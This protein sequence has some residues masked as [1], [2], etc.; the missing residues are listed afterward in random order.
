MLLAV[1]VAVLAVAVAGALVVIST[2]GGSREEPG[3]DAAPSSTVPTPDRSDSPDGPGEEYA[4]AP[5][6]D[7]GA[8]GTTDEPWGTLQHAL[9]QLRPGDRLLV[10]G[11]LYEE[12]VDLD[13]HPAERSAPVEVVAAEGE[14]P[15]V[16]GLL[17]L[18][19]ASWWD[20]Q[21]INVTWDD[22]NGPDDHMVKLTDGVG[23]R[24]ADAELWGAQSYAAL[25]VDG[26]PVDF[27]LSGLY[28]HDT[29]Q[30]N[31][32]NQDHLVYL[33]SGRG[34]GVLERSILAYSENGRAVK[35]GPADDDGDEV[36]NIV[37]RYVTM[38]D[39]RGPSNV[40]LSYNA[41]RVVVENSIMVGAAEGRANV[42]AFD[43]EGEENVIRNS[44]GWHSTQVLE[45]DEGLVDGGGNIHLDPKLGSPDA[46]RPFY[47]TEPGAQ[48]YGRWAPEG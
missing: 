37:I 42:T 5:G 36:A 11:G 23:W 30:A 8:A 9:A 26:E 4:V 12:N 27:T 45:D 22:D 17:W 21:G 39:N 2:T 16:Q 40:Q 3:R 34:G 25:L 13:V 31:G 10:G 24:F 18:E 32:T 33:N 35:V 48:R 19:D 29:R 14:R 28:V 15:V 1:A 38:V 6:G 43:L 7:D 44:L 41:S 20:I 46:E 47:P